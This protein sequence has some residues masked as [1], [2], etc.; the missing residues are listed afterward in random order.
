VSIPVYYTNSASVRGKDAISKERALC[1]GERTALF[2]GPVPADKLPKD[3]TPGRTMSGSLSLGQTS[4]GKEAPGA[5]QLL[6][7]VPPKAESKGG[8]AA[9]PAAEDK[10]AGE[11]APG[12][13]KVLE[14]A[15]R[16][17]S[18]KVLKVRVLCRQIQIVFCLTLMIVRWCAVRLSRLLEGCRWGSESNFN[19]KRK[20]RRT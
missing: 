13:D 12:P 3:A 14:E 19:T 8:A 6:F 20:P 17:A 7:A 18:I 11:G 4:A 5:L 10:E 1:L 2:V 15:V 9:P 16:D